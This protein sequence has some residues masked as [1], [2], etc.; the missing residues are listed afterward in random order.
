MLTHPPAQHIPRWQVDK[1][2][3]FLR[4][5]RTHSDASLAR[6]AASIPQFEFIRLNFVFLKVR[7]TANGQAS[8]VSMIL[9]PCSIAGCTELTAIGLCEAHR[10]ERQRENALRRGKTAER[11]YGAD[12]RRL[13][14]VKLRTDP[15]CEIR[16]HCH[17]LVA[18]EV[19]HIRPVRERPDLRLEWSNL[20]STCHGCHVAKTKQEV[21]APGG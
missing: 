18:S 9:H 19:D 11:G 4:N 7:M 17:G 16:T 14:A 21:R 13:R 6:I 10:R 15:I 1:L 20:Q 8:I 5:R 12:W 3:I 2:I